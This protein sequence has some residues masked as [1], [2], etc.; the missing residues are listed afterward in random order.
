M[1]WQAQFPP[2]AQG[3]NQA[4]S[5]QPFFNNQENQFAYQPA[6]IPGIPTSMH[7]TDSAPAP[8]AATTESISVPPLNT[9]RL[10]AT[11]YKTKNAIMSILRT[12]EV[13]L[14]FIKYKS[15]YKEDRVTDICWISGDGMRIIIYQPDPGRCV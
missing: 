9:N 1:D 7:T 12:G 15:K 2:T 3:Y 14:E 5:A 6:M 11:R 4:K 13:V 8:N 10:Q